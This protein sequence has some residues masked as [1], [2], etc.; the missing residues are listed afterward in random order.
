MNRGDEACTTQTETMIVAIR[1]L[2]RKREEG[3]QEDEFEEVKVE[4]E[5]WL[6]RARLRTSQVV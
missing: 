3:K 1:D 2:M 6:R 5:P 4:T